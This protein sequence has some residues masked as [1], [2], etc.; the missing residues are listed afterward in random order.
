MA[1][2]RWRNP[3]GV[4]PWRTSTTRQRWS[5]RLA[6]NND[7][8]SSDDTELGS[9]RHSQITFNSALFVRS[10]SCVLKMHSYYTLVI[11]IIL[12]MGRIRYVSFSPCNYVIHISWS[13]V[14]GNASWLEMVCFKTK[15]RDG[16]KNWSFTGFGHFQ[17]G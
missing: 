5:R 9:R 11:Q 4:F 17:P 2:A 1:L 15:L 14:S 7:V 13:E 12:L 8:L 3:K 10:C 6:L 16:Q